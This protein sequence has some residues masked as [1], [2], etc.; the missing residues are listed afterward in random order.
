MEIVSRPPDPVKRI[1]GFGGLTLPSSAPYNAPLRSRRPTL[2]PSGTDDAPRT[3]SSTLTGGAGSMISAGEVASGM[4]ERSTETM[5]IEVNGRPRT[6]P[7]GTSVAE[8][9]QSMQLGAP[10]AAVEVNLALVPKARHGETRLQPG[11]RVE[12]VSLVGGG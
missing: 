1:R 9:L 8:L 10:A 3:G 7:A 4:S 5:E 2:R 11:D 6:V 12:V